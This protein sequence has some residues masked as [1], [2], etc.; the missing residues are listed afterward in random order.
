MALHCLKSE[1]SP[2]LYCGVCKTGIPYT[3]SKNVSRTQF[4]SA[5]LSFGKRMM[6]GI[7]FISSP[8]IVSGLL[9]CTA[10][11]LSGDWA[12]AFPLFLIAEERFHR[13]FNA[14]R[15]VLRNARWKK[16]AVSALML[17]SE[18]YFG[19]RSVSALLGIPMHVVL[20]GI[21]LGRMYYRSV[22]AHSIGVEQIYDSFLRQTYTRAGVR[23]ED[24]NL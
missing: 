12:I 22:I 9:A 6:M 23:A 2:E 5:C 19:A 1:N 17:S 18:Y 24:V 14:Q 21:M 15:I 7:T 16:G 20:Y 10:S 4:A 11:L 8:F 3:I 13:Y